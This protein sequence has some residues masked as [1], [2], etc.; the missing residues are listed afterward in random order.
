M[1][2]ATRKIDIELLKRLYDE[3]GL[4]VDMLPHSEQERRIVESYNALK[5]DHVTE[6]EVYIALM[7]LRKRSQLKR[8]PYSRGG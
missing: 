4:T 7:N 8:K 1:S 6:R 3:Q 5:N 2:T